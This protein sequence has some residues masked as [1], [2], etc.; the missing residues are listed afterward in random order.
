MNGMKLK[1]EGTVTPEKYATNTWYVEGVGDK[2]V[3]IKDSDLVITQAYSADVEVLFD[4]NDFDKLPYSTAS[5][6]AATKDYVVI[7]RGSPDKNA[8]SRNN[9]WFHKTVIEKAAELN[10]E[11]FNVDQSARAKRPIIEFVAGLKLFQFGTEAKTEDVNLV[12]TFT[13]DVFSTISGADGY[14]IDGV[15]VTDGMRILFTADNDLRVNNNIYKVKFIKHNSTVAQIALIEETDTVPATNQ[16]ALITQGTNA[17]KQ[18]YYNGTSWK[19]AQYKSSTNQQPLFDLCDDAG[20]SYSDSTTYPV[21]DFAGNKVFSYKVGTGKKDTELGFPI[22]YRALENV[23]DITF[24]F[25]LATDKFSYQINNTPFSKTTEIGF[26]K[27]FTDIDTST[28]HNGWTKA[29]TNTVQKVI[30][31]YDVTTATADFAIDTYNNS[32]S[33]TDL[34][35]AVQVNSAWRFDYALVDVNGVMTVRFTTAIPA[36]S[37][38]VLKTNSDTTKNA[39]GY[40]EFPHAMEKNP[41]NDKLTSFTLGEVNDHVF[42]M[43]EDMPG[44]TGIFP[45]PSN[46]GNLGNV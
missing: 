44:F 46:L 41:Q 9:R 13:T 33:L 3:L 16:V 35:V 28:Y 26:L 15:D 40:Y 34:T 21:S 8:W 1:F 31:Q 43:I 10:G 12:D 14:S 20:N 11:V 42:S 4:A 29:K 38:V 2:I 39:N 17:G 19:L 22:T 36:N 7:N 25:N 32:G 27:R 5:S 6:Y 24:D 45:G 37:S 30:R 23:G 18:Y